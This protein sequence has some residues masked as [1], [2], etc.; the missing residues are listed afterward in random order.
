[1]NLPPM[2][3]EQYNLTIINYQKRS[4]EDAAKDLETVS[5][6]VWNAI[7]TRVINNPGS[8]RGFRYVAVALAT[9]IVECTITSWSAGHGGNMAVIAGNMASCNYP[10]FYVSRPLIKALSH[11]HPP[12]SM[13]WD[14]VKLPYPGLAFMLP[15]GTAQ[16][17]L[18]G[19]DAAYDVGCIF[20]SRMVKGSKVNVPATRTVSLPTEDWTEDR[21]T[22]AW[23]SGNGFHTQD[24]T[25][26]VSSL[27]E[28]NPNWLDEMTAK[29][30]DSNGYTDGKAD[31]TFAVY[32]CALASNLLLLMTAMPELVEESK[33]RPVTLKSGKLMYSPN[34]IGRKYVTPSRPT[35]S[36]DT[37]YTELGWRSGHFKR[38]RFG[39]KSA[40]QKTIWVEPY[41]AHVR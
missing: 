29:F 26:P 15:I 25:F 28:P 13:T 18:R 37:H 16:Q 41:I 31:S 30:R 39:P 14:E 9:S 4:T 5:P 2:S 34:Y 6:Q 23:A 8:H 19:S 1:M 33:D 38:Q 27:L 7:N 32:M 12:P 24:C 35:E 20:V 22:V 21:M 3:D 36:T 17:K 10:V 40:E 11:S